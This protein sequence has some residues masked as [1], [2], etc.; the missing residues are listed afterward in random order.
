M[1][2][3]ASDAGN[4]KTVVDLKLHGMLKLLLLIMKHF[5]Q[6]LGLCHR[7]GK[8]VKDETVECLDTG[9]GTPEIT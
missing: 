3:A 6:S 8:A 5:V 7:S 4:K 9:L 2:K 1:N